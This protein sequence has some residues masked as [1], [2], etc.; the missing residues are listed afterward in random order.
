MKQFQVIYVASNPISSIEEHA[1]AGLPQLNILDIVACKLSSMPPIADIKD[2][3][4]DLSLHENQISFV[5]HDYFTGCRKLRTLSL[6]GNLLTEFPDVTDLASTLFALRLTHNAIVNFPSWMLQV[7]MA[8]LEELALFG[9][10][11]EAFPPM[12]LC[13][14]L[15]LRSIE[16]ERNNLTSLTRYSDVTRGIKTTIYVEDNPLHCNS[17][18]AWLSR[19]NHTRHDDV[20]TSTVE[21]VGGQCGSPPQLR[22]RSLDVIGVYWF[23]QIYPSP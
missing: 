13:R 17:S 6:A 15:R 8:Q 16:L 14:Q 10:Q 5:P 7:S 22:G 11:I 1:F 19:H 23:V 2:T 18:L 20:F 4:I 12:I 9:N 3:L 21:Y